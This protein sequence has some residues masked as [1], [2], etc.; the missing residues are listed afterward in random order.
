MNTFVR[1]ILQQETSL[2]ILKV[3][4][5][6]M[7]PDIYGLNTNSKVFVKWRTSTCILV[8]GAITF[9]NQYSVISVHICEMSGE[10]NN[11]YTRLL[12]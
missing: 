5:M 4:F 11:V 10:K 1:V 8:F 12:V 2:G 6:R 9:I 7:G 3:R